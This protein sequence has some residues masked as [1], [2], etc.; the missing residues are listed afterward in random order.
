MVAVQ[1]PAMVAAFDGDWV[2]WQG[3]KFR[4]TGDAGLFDRDDMVQ[5]VQEFDVWDYPPSSFMASDGTEL[6]TGH[7]ILSTIL[8]PDFALSSSKM[9]IKGGR[10]L[11]GTL[12]AGLLNG[13]R[14]ILFHMYRDYCAETTARFIFEGYRMFQL[15]LDLHGH[16]CSYHDCAIDA[17]DTVSSKYK[18]HMDNF[19]QVKQKVQ[20]VSGYVDTLRDHNPSTGD[21]LT[22][23]NILDHAGQLTTLS[24]QAVMQYHRAKGALTN[25]MLLMIESKSKGSKFTL[26]QMC[27]LVGQSYVLFERFADTSSHFVRNKCSLEAYGFVSGNYATGLS[28]PA[29]VAEAH[30]TCEAVVVKIKGTS[31]SGYTVR[32]LTNGL[33]GAVVDY[34]KRVVDSNGRILWNLYGNDGFDSLKLS[35]VPLRLASIKEAAVLQRYGTCWPIGPILNAAS[36]ACK[37]LLTGAPD[38]S[39]PTGQWLAS[40]DRSDPTV[41]TQPGASFDPVLAQEIVHLFGLR[42]K[43]Q[44][45]VSRQPHREGSTCRTVR[46][47]FDFGHWFDRASALDKGS[48][49]LSLRSYASFAGMLWRKLL[50]LKLVVDTNV[51][52]KALYFD[53]FSSRSLQKRA[54]NLYQLCWLAKRLE[55]RLVDCR[56]Q[57]G[58]AVGIMATHNLGEPFSQMCLKSTHHAGKF[59]G[60]TSGTKRLEELVEASCSQPQMTIIMKK[61]TTESEATFFALSL[62]CCYLKDIVLGSP[63]VTFTGHKV[64]RHCHIHFALDKGQV[65]ARTIAIRAATV[66]LAM[67]SGMHLGMFETS[68]MDDEGPW[69]IRIRLSTL[70]NFWVQQ[71]SQIASKRTRL[72]PSEQ[73]VADNIVFN[74]LNRIPIHGNKAF[75]DFV[76][77]EVRVNSRSGKVKRVCVNTQGS[78]LAYVLRLPQVDPA[79]TVC[80]DA[81]EMCRIFGKYAGRKQIEFEFLQVMK[82]LVDLRHIKLIARAMTAHFGVVGMKRGA[83]VD[84]RPSMQRA[85]F[86]RTSANLI[87]SCSIGE[88]DDGKTLCGALLMNKR[89][90][91]GTGYTFE[92]KSPVGHL[93][94]PAP[95][96]AAGAEDSAIKVCD[97]VFS[98][99]AD[100]TRFFLVFCKNHKDQRLACLVNRRFEIFVMHTTTGVPDVLYEG[101]ILDG[102]MVPSSST[103][104]TFLAFD[105]FMSCGH[106]AVASL[107]F[108]QRLEIA[109][110]VVWLGG[111]GATG[112]LRKGEEWPMGLDEAYALPVRRPEVS[113]YQVQIGTLPF[114]VLVKP[115]FSMRGIQHYHRFWVK[116]G[117]MP[118]TTDGYVMTSLFSPAYPFRMEPTSVFKWKG[119]TADASENTVDFVVTGTDEEHKKVPAKLT[120]REKWAYEISPEQVDSFRVTGGNCLLWSRLAKDRPICFGSGF[121]PGRFESGQVYEC[122]WNFR[123]RRW[124]LLRLRQKAANGWDTVVRTLN[125]IVEDI[126]INEL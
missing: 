49:T 34:W 94:L 102:E 82:A 112:A 11:F 40:L 55:Q 99:K 77:Q 101:T 21:H 121:A 6:W 115:T 56:I 76:V 52:L 111:H 48:G 104:A 13:P 89:Q 27:G 108:D 59:A 64:T 116:A 51:G 83:I 39:T 26:N 72:D 125:N 107:R 50:K 33:Q 35:S 4:R 43:L 68:F 70:C 105:C 88:L 92:T 5:L 87:R 47:P 12:D 19:A 30:P 46:T 61:G 2:D 120:G 63:K 17:R 85:S 18:V 126:T 109:R 73:T 58:E 7:S 36:S 98:P 38:T 119:R 86:E 93:T 24:V 95:A 20:D 10:M 81:T 25:G 110:E 65:V 44:L 60:A 75:T 100:G 54:F 90:E 96:P 106:Q 123:L 78:N 103:R 62:V 8:P 28:L 80:N 117:R 9:R 15:A 29:V 16:T 97:Y 66:R 37:Q 118:F 14:G 42:R 113:R 67:A 32:K 45:M 122:Q 3:V 23:T 31:K 91:V 22:E 79:R 74:L 41:W 69:S 1:E 114:T 53:W 71:S 124:D 84:S 57:P